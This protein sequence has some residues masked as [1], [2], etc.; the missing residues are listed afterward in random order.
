MQ[1]SLIST[2]HNNDYFVILEDMSVWD[3]IKIA[4]SADLNL[5]KPIHALSKHLITFNSK[6]CKNIPILLLYS[7]Q[8][9]LAQGPLQWIPMLLQRL[10]AESLN[11]RFSADQHCQINQ[12]RC[13]Y[14]NTYIVPARVYVC[15]ENC[16]SPKKKRRKCPDWQYHANKVTNGKS[17]NYKRNR[18]VFYQTESIL[19]ES[20]Q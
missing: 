17:N 19:I 9:I 16:G 6:K 10:L 7:A 4:F 15:S 2:I 5:W 18:V 12:D 13:M 8:K 20:H 3:L 11:F 14:Q 1:F